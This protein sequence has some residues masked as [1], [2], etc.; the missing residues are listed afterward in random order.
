MVYLNK[1]DGILTDDVRTW[2]YVSPLFYGIDQEIGK[3]TLSNG[4]R[5]GS[6]MFWSVVWKRSPIQS[7]NSH[8]TIERKVN[9]EIVKIE[10]VAI[11]NAANRVVPLNSSWSTPQGNVVVG[12]RDD[13]FSVTSVISELRTQI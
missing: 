2:C 4:T 11:G 7:I 8:I 6:N 13:D 1:R 12:A 3:A 10:V 9:D 5:P